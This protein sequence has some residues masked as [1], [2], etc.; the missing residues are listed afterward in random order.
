MAKV[1][2]ELQDGGRVR[3]GDHLPPHRYI[4]NTSTRGTA[5]IEHPLN[6]GR[7]P[8]TSQKRGLRALLKGA[9]EMGTSRC[10]QR[11]PQRRARDAKA[12]AAA[13]KKPVCKHSSLST[14]SL[15]G[16][17]AARHCQGPV[18]R[19]QLPLEN[20]RRASRWCNVMLASAATGLPRIRTPPSLRP[21]WARAPEAAAPLTPSCLSEEQTPSGNLQAEAGPNPKLNPGSC[22][23]KEEKG[24]SL[25]AASEAAD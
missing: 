2:E 17:C 16:A 24:K 9:P 10:Y 3:H 7:R 18:I 23:N 1:K 4:R 14:P 13:T 8:Q 22:A 20:A 5:P 19:G 21:E 6:A 25:P 11:G 15:P 12:A